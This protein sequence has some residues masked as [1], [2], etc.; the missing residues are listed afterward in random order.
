MF[1]KF[2]S[3][4]QDQDGV[5]VTF[6]G[7]TTSHGYILVGADGAHSAVSKHLYKTMEQDGILPETDAKAMSVRYV[8][9]VGTTDALDPAKFPGVLDEESE[10]VFIVG[11]KNTPYTVSLHLIPRIVLNA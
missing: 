2:P 3:F 7:S 10:N 5:T 9:L 11:D 1:N 6:G 8:S 4:D